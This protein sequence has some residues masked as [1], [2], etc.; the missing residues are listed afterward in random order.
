LVLFP[1]ASTGKNTPKHIKL[2]YEIS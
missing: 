2:S 1:E